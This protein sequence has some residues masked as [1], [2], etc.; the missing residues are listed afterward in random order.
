MRSPAFSP[1]APSACATR[2]A[3][4]SSS[5]YV[6]LRPSNASARRSGCAFA[7][8]RGMSPSDCRR[9]TDSLV[10]TP[11]LTG[12][13]RSRGALSRDPLA[14]AREGQESSASEAV[15]E[16]EREE[17]H[18]FLARRFLVAHALE[19]LVV[20]TERPRVG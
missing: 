20:Q 1:R 14:F 6:V 4:S 5:A 7:W 12:V 17:I 3:R 2:L 19:Q 16:S 8:T 10:M 15:R 13:R 18:V 11:P 9:G